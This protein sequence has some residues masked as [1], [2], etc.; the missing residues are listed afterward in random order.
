MVEFAARPEAAY[1]LAIMLAIG[2]GLAAWRRES[3]AWITTV[4]IS[5]VFVIV[6]ATRTDALFLT[7][8][9]LVVLAVTALIARTADLA[10]SPL[11]AGEPTWRKVLLVLFHE[12]RVR[13]SAEAAARA[14]RSVP[15]TGPHGP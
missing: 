7:P 5:T 3:R 8:V 2:A 4:L 6:A 9:Y 13:E 12:A 15:P 14:P 1:V 10:D 11:L